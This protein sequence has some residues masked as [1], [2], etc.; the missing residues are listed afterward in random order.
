MSTTPRPIRRAAEPREDPDRRHRGARSD[1]DERDAHD[2]EDAPEDPAPRE[3]LPQDRD[4][5]ERDEDRLRGAE[6]RRDPARQ[7]LR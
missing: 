3:P 2:A 6:R 4:R 5:E 1:D 7:V